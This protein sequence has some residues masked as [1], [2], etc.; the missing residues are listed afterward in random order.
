MKIDIDNLSSTQRKIRVELPGEAVDKE[1]VRVYENLGRQAKIKGFRPGK[2]PRSVLQG[3]Y[4]D[5][6]KGQVLSRL[7]ERSLG[8]VIKERG[9]KIVAEP[10]VEAETL[11]EGRDFSFS[12]LVEIKPDVD[13]KNYFGVELK[14]VKLSV[15]DEQVEGALGRLREAHAQLV[16]VED[17]DVVERG[18][19]VTLD[20]SGTVDGAP[21][22]GGKNENYSVEVGGGNTLPEFENALIGL[23]KDSEETITVPYPAD[24]FKKELAGKSALFSVTV[25]EIKKKVLPALDDEFAKD[26]AASAS[27]EELKNKI[28]AQLEIELG[29][30]QKEALKEQLMERLVEAHSFEL[31]ESLIDR[32]VRYLLERQ[33]R[34]AAGAGEQPSTEELRKELRPHAERQVKATL[35]LE[36]I[37]ENEKVEVAD[38]DV[39]KRI[40]DAARAAGERSAAVRQYYARPDARE[41]LKSQMIMDRTIGLLLER[42]MAKEV[43]PTVDA[44]EKKS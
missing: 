25:R 11:E 2:A 6:I 37:A 40:E 9:L 15:S 26:H 28:R 14:K 31:P 43:E 35:L 8:E 32:Q 24:Y 10:E 3:I 30:F 38:A 22:P 5:E 13:A 1:F 17:R 12:A 44:P 42:A 4:G 18:D 33:Q 27:L 16:P 36:K 19:F 29:E 21:I 41:S 23:K 20:F 39:Q 34:N 7:V